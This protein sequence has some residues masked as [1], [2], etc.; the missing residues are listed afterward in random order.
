HYWQARH[1]KTIEVAVGACGVPLAWTKFPLAEGEHEIIDFMND[2]WPLPHQRP[3]FV[4]IDKACQVLASLNACGM[5]VPPN[6]WFSHN[7]WLKVETWHYT[8]HVIDELCVT[9]CNP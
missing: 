3:G 1:I 9:W 8:R 4:V 6:G 7:T 5:L 2:V